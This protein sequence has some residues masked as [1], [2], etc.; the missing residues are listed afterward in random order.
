MFNLRTKSFKTFAR[1]FGTRDYLHGA[2]AERSERSRFG[3]KCK[4]WQG[5]HDGTQACAHV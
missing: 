5:D 4:L 3:R 1:A 2:T